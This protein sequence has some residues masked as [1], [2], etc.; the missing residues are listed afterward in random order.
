MERSMRVGGRGSVRSERGGEEGSGCGGFRLGSATRANLP[1]AKTP[2]GAGKGSA[3]TRRLRKKMTNDA[4]LIEPLPTSLSGPD[5]KS[6]LVRREDCRIRLRF[7][8]P[9]IRLRSVFSQGPVA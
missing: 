1:D 8:Q 7:A 9:L 5:F 6:A 4:T 2:G 3:H